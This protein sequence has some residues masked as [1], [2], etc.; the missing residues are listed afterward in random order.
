MAA[1]FSPDDGHPLTVVVNR[2]RMVSDDEAGY[3]VLDYQSD[4]ARWSEA[5]GLQSRRRSRE[6]HQMD[7]PGVRRT[8]QS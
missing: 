6:D 8:D 7:A 1:T 2:S 4:P 3:Q 5:T